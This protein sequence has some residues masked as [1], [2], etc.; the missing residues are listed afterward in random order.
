MEYT[1][2]KLQKKIKLCR[3]TLT[4][5]NHKKILTRFWT[6]SEKKFFENTVLIGIAMW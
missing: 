3:E 5:M 2:F 1:P 6:L 4:L